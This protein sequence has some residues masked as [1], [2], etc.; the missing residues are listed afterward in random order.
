[1][2]EEREKVICFGEVLW[3]M[4]PGGKKIGGAPLNVAYHLHKLGINSILVS[5]VG[6]DEYGDEVKSFLN[7]KR[8]SQTG[9]QTD[10]SHPTGKAEVNLHSSQE[11]TFE[12][13]S[14]AAW[15]YIALNDKL[16][17]IVDGTNYIVFGSLITRH[18]PSRDTLLHLLNLIP[19]TIFDIN[20]RK[21]FYSKE[22]IEALLKKAEIVK[23]NESELD[24]IAK[25][26]NA[27]GSQRSQMESLSDRFHLKTIIITAGAKGAFAYSNGDYVFG[28]PYKVPIADT[29]GSGDASL[30]G[31]LSTYMKG[32][33]LQLSLEAGNKMGALIAQK[34][35]GCPEYVIEELHE[36]SNL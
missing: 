27:N 21:P 20:L 6:S 22:I 33:N 25:W 31:F 17:L 2:S 15:D 12:I 23:M 30:A 5:R 18:Q 7:Q 36:I 19:H 13:S 24:I 35:G 1:M 26:F 3:D 14:N 16:N 11:V 4:L 10:N 9:L 29:V 34:Q 32:G 8:L 28:E